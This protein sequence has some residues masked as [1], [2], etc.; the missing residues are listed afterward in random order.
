MFDK[1]IESVIRRGRRSNAIL[2]VTRKYLCILAVFIV[3]S[4][5]VLQA[6][7]NPNDNDNNEMNNNTDIP[8]RNLVDLSASATELVANE[9]IKVTLAS[10][11]RGKDP[12][13]LAAQANEDV[14]WATELVDKKQSVKLSSGNYQTFPLY[15]QGNQSKPTW[16]LVQEIVISSVSMEDVTQLLGEL[17]SRL[18]IRNTQ[19]SITPETR[20]KVENQLIEQ[21]MQAFR[22]RALVIGRAMPSA[23]YEIVHIAVRTDTGNHPEMRMM[24]RAAAV[25]MEA[26]SAMSAPTV[27]AGQTSI[28]VQVSGSVVYP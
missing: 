10:E 14:A 23:D 6:A 9:E 4:G 13:E 20:R 17:Q 25:Q 22:E 26:T 15:T 5:N 21:A 11:R 2:N 18:Q 12:S 8:S 1:V 24:G 19:F 28:T 3:S 7:D 16:Q 27:E